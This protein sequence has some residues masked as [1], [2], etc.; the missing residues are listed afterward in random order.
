MIR[1]LTLVILVCGFIAIIFYLIDLKNNKTGIKK[2]KN[3]I[4]NKYPTN[5][6]SERNR[7]TEK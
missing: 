2:D 1:F 5:K 4:A 6:N 3:K 7:F